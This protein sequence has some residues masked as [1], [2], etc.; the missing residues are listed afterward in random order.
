MALYGGIEITGRPN[1]ENVRRLDLLPM[2]SIGEMMRY[3]MSVD[4]PHLNLITEQLSDE[5]SELRTEICLEIPSEKLDEFIEKSGMDAEDDYLPMNVDSVQ[6]MRRLLFEVLG[7]GKG[8]RLKLTKSGDVSTGKKQLEQRKKDHPIVQ[9]VLNYREMSKLKSTYSTT[10]PRIAK[11]HPEKNCWCGLKHFAETHRV[12]TEILTTRA[13]TGRC[14]SK[15]P[16]LQNIPV[17]T[18]LGRSIRAGFIAS[19][20]TEIA[21]ADFSQMEMRIGGHYSGDEN[22]LRIFELGLDPHLDTAMRAFKLEE[23]QIDK[24]LHRDPARHLNFGIFYGLTPEGLFDQIGVTYATARVEMPEWLT[25][26]WCKGFINQWF[27]ELYPRVKEYLD[28]Q[29]YR[30]AR[31]NMVWTLFGR[32][33][34]VPEVRS[35]HSR[36]VAAGLRQAGN[37]PIQGTGADMMKLALAE[38]QEECERI[39][40]AG[41]WVWPLMTVHDEIL[42][43]VEQGYG[44]IVQMMM[45]DV[46][47]RVMVDKESGVDGFRVKVKADG[48]VMSRW[49]K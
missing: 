45:E 22:L 47:S 28:N 25:L 8:H 38:I 6:Q 21:R 26:E 49:E 42:I 30:A 1:L 5:M 4:I 10:L 20:G 44:S 48:K 11:F 7:V 27:E 2:R 34:R 40:L 9:L 14:T 13:S 29:H 19:P 36:V 12:H 17:R 41:V 43:E 39:R 32:I 16:N 31:Y 37:M 23:D 33:R 15:N 35:V 46:M 18:K 24:L 3:G